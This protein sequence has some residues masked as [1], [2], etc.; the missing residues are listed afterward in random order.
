[1]DILAVNCSPARM[2]PSNG[3]DNDYTLVKRPQRNLQVLL[4]PA[5]EITPRII[6]VDGDSSLQT[7]LQSKT[8]FSV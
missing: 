4:L 3:V 7:L 6:T 5:P 1:M 2:S 8:H